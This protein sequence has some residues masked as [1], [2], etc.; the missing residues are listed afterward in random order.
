M[1]GLLGMLSLDDPDAEENCGP[2]SLKRELR[3][4]SFLILFGILPVGWE[5]LR[6]F[7]GGM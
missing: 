3:D 7:E 4:F 1:L 6:S 5:F 2:K